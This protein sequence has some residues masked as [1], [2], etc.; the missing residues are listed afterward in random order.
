MPRLSLA[1]VI[2]AQPKWFAAENKRFFNDQTY[3]VAR[4]ASGKPFLVRSTYGWTDM[5]GGPKRLHFRLNPLDPETLEIQNLVDQI[6][7][8]RDEVDQYLRDN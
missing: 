2:Q 8:D 1:A 3:D 5:L 7:A 6:F 4:S